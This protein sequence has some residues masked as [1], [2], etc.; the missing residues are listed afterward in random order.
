MAGEF[1]SMLRQIDTLTDRLLSANLALTRA[2]LEKKK[3]ELSYLRSQINPHFLHNT[4]ETIRGAA[5]IE[6]AEMTLDMVGSLAR[7]FR[8]CV[9]GDDWVTL[10]EEMQIISSYVHIQLIRFSSRFRVEYDLDE[11]ALDALV[12]KML[13]QPVVENAFH[14]GLEGREEQG[15]LRIDGHLANGVLTVT[16]GDNGR[17]MDESQLALVSRQLRDGEGTSRGGGD[18]AGSIGL[19]NVS[20]RIKLL[21]GEKYGVRI[22]SEPARGT[23]V[24]LT[25]PG[26]TD[27]VPAV[28]G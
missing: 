8:Y 6:K 19:A 18:G 10:R 9:A 28:P 24:T 21:Y 20:N 17:G 13:L 3:A 25:L 16:V 2:E 5:L 7:M 1:N 27:G 23:L 15:T 14:H 22:T 4:L 12:P 26:R 11:G